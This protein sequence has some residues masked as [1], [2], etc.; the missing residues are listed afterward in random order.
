MT[1]ILADAN[2]TKQLQEAT[3]P[4]AVVNDQG[5]MIGYCMPIKFPHSPYSR[6]EITRRREEARKHPDKNKSF[7]EVVAHLDQLAGDTP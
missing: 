7:A 1:Q 5:T 2:M 6:E 4:V 3:G